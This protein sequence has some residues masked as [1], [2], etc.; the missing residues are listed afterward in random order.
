MVPPSHL[1][2]DIPAD[3]EQIVLRCLAKNPADRYQ[4]AASLA[5]PLSASARPPAA[6]R[7]TTPPSGGMTDGVPSRQCATLRSRWL[8]RPRFVLGQLI[9]QPV[10]HLQ[11]R[12]P[13]P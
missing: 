10:P 3:L 4:D 9:W 13:T 5:R 2:P 6:G 7:A 11:S 1:R 12:R 8:E